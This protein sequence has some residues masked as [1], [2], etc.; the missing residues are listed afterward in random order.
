MKQYLFVFSLL[1]SYFA[2]AQATIKEADLMVFEPTLA[3]KKLNTAYAENMF[4]GLFG[5]KPLVNAIPVDLKNVKE[6]TVSSASF[7]GKKKKVFSA[8]YNPKGQLV[9]FELMEELGKPLQVNYAYK[10]DVIQHETITTKD[11]G[12]KQHAF[13]YQGDKMY[14]KN[15]NQLF[16]VIWLEDQIMMKKTFLEEKLGFEDRLMHNCRITKSL[17]QDINKVCFSS[18]SLMLP[19][20]IKEYT[21]DVNV[22][23]QK[24]NMLEGGTSEIVA[25]SDKQY[26][27]IKQGTKQFTILLNKD[28]RIQQF[29]FLGNAAEKQNPLNFEFTYS[30]Y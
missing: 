8:K 12:T 30:Y 26:G 9:S 15:A 25:E 29:N 27:I 13:Y 19:F 11:Q 16:D 14:V 5:I 18:T 24:V 7:T 3:S 6:I 21:P 22:K 17:G 10:D 23:T 2:T 20:K 4:F 28:N 1:F